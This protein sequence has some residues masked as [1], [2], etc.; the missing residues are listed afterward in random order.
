M[1]VVR[2]PCH[3]GRRNGVLLGRV[4]SLAV[5]DV[6]LER[7]AGPGLGPRTH[8]AQDALA[9]EVIQIT[10]DRHRANAELLGEFFDTHR[11]LRPHELRDLLPSLAEGAAPG[12]FDRSH[13]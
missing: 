10:V 13:G 11:T 9:V 3:C 6:V 5:T 2:R 7:L 4:E 12:T 1:N 8:L